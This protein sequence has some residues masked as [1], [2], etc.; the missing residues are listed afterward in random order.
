MGSTIFGVSRRR[1]HRVGRAS[2]R[3]TDLRIERFA[4]HQLQPLALEVEADGFL[5]NMVRNIVG[6]LV[7]GGAR[8]TAAGLDRRTSWPHGIAR[9]PAPPHRPAA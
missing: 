9:K 1:V 4:R 7:A 8:R 2:A 3:Y 5:Y 6:S